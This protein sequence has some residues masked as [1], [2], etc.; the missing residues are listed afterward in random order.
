MTITS[1]KASLVHHELLGGRSFPF[2]Y[3]LGE[4]F[5]VLEALAKLDFKEAAME[6]SQV[7]YAIQMYFYQLTRI[8]F[9]LLCCSK[10]VQGFYDRRKVWHRIFDLYHTPFYNDY[11]YHGSNYMRPV[12]IKKALELAGVDIDLQSAEEILKEILKNGIS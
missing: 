10:V 11:L 4:M 1:R 12:K 8:D 3:I 2:S 7:L 6:A 9:T 5:E